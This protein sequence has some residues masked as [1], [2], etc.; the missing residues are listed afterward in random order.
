MVTTSCQVAKRLAAYS[1]VKV[2]GRDLKNLPF[3]IPVQ[4]ET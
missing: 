2:I 3:S 1:D 4:K